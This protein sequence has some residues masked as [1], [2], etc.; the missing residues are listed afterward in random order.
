[1]YAGFIAKPIVQYPT[2]QRLL[3]FADMSI[4]PPIRHLKTGNRALPL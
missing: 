2:E 4:A 3:I 1:M